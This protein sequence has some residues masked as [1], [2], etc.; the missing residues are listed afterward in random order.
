MNLSKKSG[1]IVTGGRTG[2][3][4]GGRAGVFCFGIYLLHNLIL[5]FYFFTIMWTNLGE[6]FWRHVLVEKIPI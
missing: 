5:F 6:N 3:R 2:G 4:A 1:F